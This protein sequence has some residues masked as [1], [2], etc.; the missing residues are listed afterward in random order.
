MSV[1]EKLFGTFEGKPVKQ[2]TLTSDAGV[3]VDIIEYGAAVRD[4]RVPVGGGKRSV[5]LGFDTLDDYV[6]HSPYFGA[7][8]G[9]VANRIGGA[10]FEIAGKRYELPAN[11]GTSSLHSGPEGLSK[12]VWTGK[13]DSAA[14]A[15]TLSFNQPDGLGGFPGNVAYKV[16]Y[17]LSGKKLRLVFG[18]TSDAVTPISLVQHLYFN[19]SSTDE[20]IL[21]HRYKIVASAFTELDDSL[22]PNGNIIEVT[23]GGD[24][25]L[26]KPR[27]LRRADGSPI[28]YD[29]NY[30]LDAGRDL[31]Q[32]VVEVT[33]P[34][35]SL[36]LKLWTDRPGVQFYDGVMTDVPVPGIGGR[37][38]PKHSG[39]CIEDQAFPDAVHHPHFPNVW[40]GPQRPY[41]HW[42]EIE[43][44]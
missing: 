37:K 13:A 16:T 43:V 31:S 30:V 40:H 14:N 23:P 4:W 1:S 22:V 29:G 39:F 20:T 28:D 26:R 12:Q 44:S 32:P 27:T 41:S 10:S 24:R 36:S 15:V 9:P 21:D 2:F 7:I 34:D 6:A 5:T 18:A 8:A 17:S 38:Y 33:A 11:E 3:E 42:C 35:G 25:D 19:L